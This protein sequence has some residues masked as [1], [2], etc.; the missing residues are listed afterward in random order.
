MKSILDVGTGTGLGLHS[1]IDK[2]SSD[3]I[4][5]GVDID[6][7]YIQAAQKRFKNI[8]NVTMNEKN[9][10]EFENSKEKFDLIIFSSSFMLMPYREKAIDIAKSMLNP[11]GKIVFLM[12]LY[13]NKRRFKFI[14]K[15]KPYLK[16]ATSIDFGKITYE[17]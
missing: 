4:I 7:D 16:Y 10:Y 3:T 9:F 6:K 8:S 13:E 15:V 5:Q 11:K 2:I 1:I 14:E 17:S 12:T